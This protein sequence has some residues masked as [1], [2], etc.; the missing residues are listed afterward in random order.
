MPLFQETW[1]GANSDPWPSSRW[2]N[3]DIPTG[4]EVDQTGA[5]EGRIASES[6]SHRAGRAIAYAD[7]SP[8]DIS[9]FEWDIEFTPVQV[10]G[11]GR[12]ILGFSFRCQG[13]DWAHGANDD[14]GYNAVMPANGYVF[15][16]YIDGTW[17]LRR[18]VG[19]SATNLDSGSNANIADGNTSRLIIRADGTTIE[20]KLWR[21]GIDSEPSFSSVADSEYASGNIR[22]ATA[23]GESGEYG[24]VLYEPFIVTDLASAGPPWTLTV[25]TVGEGTVGKD[26]DQADYADEDLVELTA[27]PDSGWQVADP[28]WTGP[29]APSNANENPT[30]VTM[31]ADKSLTA[32]FEEEPP[33]PTPSNVSVTVTSRTSATVTWDDVTE[34]DHFQVEARVRAGQDD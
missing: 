10:S 23:S 2:G 17:V 27:T 22:V 18:V 25:G 30:T 29:D 8:V 28:L 3:I 12:V 31:D 15:R 14:N 26:P 32:N 9:D 19:G 21:P 20:W 11:S 16:V 24:N 34:A 1:P 33:L 4:V 6:A 13:T 7:S 5:S